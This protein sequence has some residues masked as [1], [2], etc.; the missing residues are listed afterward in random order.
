MWLNQFLAEFGGSL[1]FHELVSPKHRGQRELGLDV[2]ICWG[3]DGVKLEMEVTGLP[4]T[5]LDLGLML[6]V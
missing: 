3:E 5:W 6:W 4:M 2:C 1:P